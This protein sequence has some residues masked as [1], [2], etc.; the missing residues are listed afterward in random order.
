MKTMKLYRVEIAP[1]VILPLGKSP[2]FSYLSS[3]PIERGTYV[4]IPFGKRAIEGIVFDCAPLPGR[5]PIWM[6]WV[7]KVIEKKFLTAEQLELAQYVSEEYFTPLGKTLKHFLPKR[8]KA[9]K[10]KVVSTKKLEI[11]RLNKDESQILRA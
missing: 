10:K 6:K 1:L 9:R 4:G 5:S 7:T 2:F 11:L 3:E 8:T